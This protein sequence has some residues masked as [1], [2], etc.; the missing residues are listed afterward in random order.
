M[1][2]KGI[3]S[4]LILCCTFLSLN[5][6]AGIMLS[7]TRLIFNGNKNE[8]VITVSNPDK[9]SYL[10]QSW[11]SVEGKKSPE[12]IVTP[13]LFRLDGLSSNALRVVLAKNHLP[14]DKES[15]FWLNVKAI[16]P[17]NPDATDALLIA[18]NTQIK[19][20]YRPSSLMGP[21]ASTAYKKLAFNIDAATQ[22][23]IATNSTAYYINLSSIMFN[24]K[25]IDNPGIVAPFSE[26]KWKIKPAATNNHVKWQ[27]INDFGGV[28]AAESQQLN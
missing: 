16:P 5:S 2:I 1:N 20:I 26:T 15:L 25:N 11:V 27:V 12:F 3:V 8:A 28:T 14:K 10:I 4:F 21:E 18:L 9:T 23:L 17:S 13:P 19:L 22:Q 24:N 7:G 6:Y